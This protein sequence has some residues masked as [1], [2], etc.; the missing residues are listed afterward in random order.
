MNCSKAK[1]GFAAIIQPLVDYEYQH[2][3]ELQLN[4]LSTLLEIS[5]SQSLCTIEQL[6]PITYKHNEHCFGRPIPFDDL[7]LLN[8]DK[9]RFLLR[10]PELDKCFHDVTTI[11]CPGN[12]LHTVL[13][14]AWLGLPCTLSSKMAFKQFH[15]ILLQCCHTPSMLLLGGR[16]YLSTG[17][18]SL[19]LYSLTSTTHLFLSPL[20]IIHVLCNTSFNTLTCFVSENHFTYVPWAT[21][22]KTSV[23]ILVP[24]IPLTSDFKVDNSTLVSLDNTYDLLHHTLTQRLTQLKADISRLQPTFITSVN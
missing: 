5:S 6:R 20:S 13:Q 3:K 17:F 12:L 2:N 15:Q 11:L 22:T 24:H 10:S 16:Y 19:S 4:L 8:C 23:N 21:A 14:P 1:T 18:H 7:L 9:Q